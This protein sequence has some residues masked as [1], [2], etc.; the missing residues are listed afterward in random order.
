MDP[1]EK[2]ETTGANAQPQ[3][4]EGA[5]KQ[6]KK[7]LNKYDS[8][9]DAVEK[10]IGGLEQGFHETRQQ[11]KAIQDLLELA[12]N[13]Q[14]PSNQGGYSSVGS[15]GAEDRRGEYGRGEFTIEDSIEPAEWITSPGKALRRV[16]EVREQRLMA[17]VG[18]FVNAAVAG[19]MAVSDF[20]RENPD[21]IE[22]E[23]IVSHFMKSTD[24]RLPVD[25]RLR[26]AAK[27]TKAYLTSLRRNGK[28]S[29]DEAGRTPN[30]EEFVEEPTGGNE[31]LRLEER[32]S[33][34]GSGN[35]KDDTLDSYIAER[36][37][38]RQKH[39]APPSKQS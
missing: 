32:A 24:P 10:G 31:D 16:N 13:P 5:G 26:Q 20:K 12:V 21:L 8:I 38:S 6:G 30:N 39:F 23:H 7:Y 3:G 1:K 37:K 22:H 34:D 33:D 29:D 27:D 28:K 17:G 14:N 15:R 2:P 25:R 11:L 18:N 4:N 19:A 36:R 35:N 9:D